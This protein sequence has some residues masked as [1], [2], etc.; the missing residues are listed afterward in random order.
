MG[1]LN[2]AWDIFAS[3]EIALADLLVVRPVRDV[4]LFGA[5]LKNVSLIYTYRGL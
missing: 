3:C 2:P 1:L 4:A 5:I